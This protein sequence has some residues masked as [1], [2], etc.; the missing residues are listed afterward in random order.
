M[1]GPLFF[2]HPFSFVLYFLDGWARLVRSF[3]CLIEQ[4][5]LGSNSIE[6]FTLIMML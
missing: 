4:E 1:G 5:I 6:H 2:L 3:A